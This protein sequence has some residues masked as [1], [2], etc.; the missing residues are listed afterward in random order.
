MEKRIREFVQNLGG[1]VL[2]IDV[3]RTT[4]GRK[5][6]WVTMNCTKCGDRIVKCWSY[7]S[8]YFT[9]CDKHSRNNNLRLTYQEVKSTIEAKGCKLLSTEYV[10]VS[11]DLEIQCKC[12]NIYKRTFANF[13]RGSYYCNSCRN[14]MLSERYRCSLD[15]VTTY[16]KSVG[17]ELES[18]YA[19]ASDP[20]ILR[21]PQGH[22]FKRSF[23]VLQKTAKCPICKG[24][25]GLRHVIEWL[26]THEIEYETEVTY[27]NLIGIGGHPLH[28]DIRVK[29]FKGEPI[30]IEYDGEYHFSPS[31]SE[32]Y[33]TIR[34]CDSLKNLYCYNNNIKLIRIPFF[35]LNSLDFLLNPI[36]NT[37]VND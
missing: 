26:E 25:V 1:E 32:S 36:L 8:D 7:R 14:D 11:T 34:V 22:V 23:S 18:E 35:K 5:K 27:P 30:L 2:S 31:Q 19:N 4:G 21:C 33:E 17:L 29:D 16:I 10:N 9:I 12:G 37:E 13:K 20:L 28:F 6:Y 24:S 3:T 15:D